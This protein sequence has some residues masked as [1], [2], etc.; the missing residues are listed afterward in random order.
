MDNAAGIDLRDQYKYT[1]AQDYNAGQDMGDIGSMLI[2]ADEV[3]TGDGL[4][5]GAAVVT[6]GSLGTTIEVTAP[7]AGLGALLVVHGNVTAMRGAYNFA[8]QKGRQSVEK[9]NS[10]KGTQNPKVKES[11]NKGNA[12][13]KDFS[14]KANQKGWDVTP[15]L[16][17]PKTGKTVRPDAVTKSGKPVELKPN[18]KSGK[19]KG[20]KQLPK[21]ERATGK[22][23]RVI[24]YDPNKY[25]N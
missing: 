17:D 9:T 14:Q 4:I 15:S 8:K 6:A 11:I 22:K 5:G 19:A 10:G 3:S 16:K 12:A 23:G 7:A 2:G 1:D 25:K 21:Y 18:T 24:T 20:E 13:H